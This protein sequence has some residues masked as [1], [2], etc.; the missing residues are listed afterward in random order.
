MATTDPCKNCDKVENLK[1]ILKTHAEQIEINRQDIAN[2][3]ADEKETKL[4]VKMILEKIDYLTLGFENLR[5]DKEKERKEKI[6]E[7]EAWKSMNSETFLLN[8][9]KLIIKI[10]LILVAIFAGLKAASLLDI[11]QLLP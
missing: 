9:F 1:E 10:L 4:Y 5:R 2:I 8:N 7:L 6:K 11:L 3:K